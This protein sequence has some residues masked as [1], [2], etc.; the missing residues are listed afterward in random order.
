MPAANNITRLLDSKK[1][2]YTAFELPAEK[3]GAL[4]TA[5]RLNTPP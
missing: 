3:L 2:R 1:I 5:R 4:E